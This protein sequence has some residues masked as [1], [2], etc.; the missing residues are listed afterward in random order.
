M[1]KSKEKQP[2]EGDAAMEQA[3]SEKEDESTNGKSVEKEPHTSQASIAQVFSFAKSTR[4]KLYM[5]LAV[6]AS[7]ISGLVLPGESDVLGNSFMAFFV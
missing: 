5:L 2:Y 3:S 1:T 7:V 6:V 4:A